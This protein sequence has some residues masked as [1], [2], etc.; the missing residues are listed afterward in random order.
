ME[1]IN[2]MQPGEVYVLGNTAMPG[3]Y[4]IGY[5]T[6]SVT[7]RIAELSS[8]T[9]VPAQFYPVVAIKTYRPDVVEREVH[10][11]LGQKRHSQKREFFTF[12]NDTEAAASVLSAIASARFYQP[13]T[14][15]V[16]ADAAIMREPEVVELTPEQEVERQERGRRAIQWLRGVCDQE[17]RS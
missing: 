12:G 15:N 4:K 13:V 3:F 1:T 5:T 9:S 2:G 10:A 6:R 14:P 16:I 11:F 8:G 7:V 17:V